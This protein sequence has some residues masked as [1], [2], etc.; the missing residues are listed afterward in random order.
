MSLSLSLRSTFGLT[1]RPTGLASVRGRSVS[2][3]Y[4]G[5]TLSSSLGFHANSRAG[6]ASHG[7]AP[8]MG[9]GVLLEPRRKAN[10]R[11]ICVCV[12]VGA[13]SSFQ[14]RAR[15]GSQRGRERVRLAPAVHIS[16]AYCADEMSDWYIQY[17]P[18]TVREGFPGGRCANESADPPRAPK[19]RPRSDPVWLTHL[20]LAAAQLAA[21]VPPREGYLPARHRANHRRPRC[22]R[23]L[24]DP[25]WT[26]RE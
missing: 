10:R 14:R 23:M 12:R 17:C 8:S 21:L 6:L 15:A 9:P 25:T 24:A 26:Q 1:A 16:T 20:Q 3:T 13:R 22:Y 11:A 7:G 4:V 5:A 2:W 19:R 18:Q